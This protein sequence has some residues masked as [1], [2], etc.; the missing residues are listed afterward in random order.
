MNRSNK[1]K[2][3]ALILAAGFSSR[4]GTF[5]PLLQLG[6]ITIIERV[7]TTF[8]CAGIT[9]IKVVIGHRAS[10]MRKVLYTLP[11]D[12][13]E[14]RDYA[15]GMFSSVKAGVKAIKPGADAFFLLPTDIPLIQPRTLDQIV[16]AFQSH[17]AG[18]IYP[19]FD[20]ERGHPPLIST[21]YIEKILSWS[22]EGGLRSLMRGWETESMDLEV[23]DQWILMD[24]DTPEDYHRIQDMYGKTIYQRNRNACPF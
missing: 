18:V 7:V 6:N 24:M 8:R 11:V 5:K 23:N 22:G 13:I 4:M 17:R 20:G 9:D 21:F 19:C 15:R 10:E 14:N 16:Q 12:A 3:A 1:E 2:I